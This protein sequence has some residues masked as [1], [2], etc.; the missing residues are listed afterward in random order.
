MTVLAIE[1]TP[2]YWWGSYIS[3]RKKVPTK[4]TMLLTHKT[5]RQSTEI[6]MWTK[7]DQFAKTNTDESPKKKTI[8]QGIYLD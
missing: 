5:S 4:K 3:T 6:Q 8:Q 7:I 1:D 2:L